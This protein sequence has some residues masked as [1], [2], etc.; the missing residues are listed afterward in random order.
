M[1]DERF[2]AILRLVWQCVVIMSLAYCCAQGMQEKI[3]LD[4][5]W[6]KI[7]C[8]LGNHSYGYIQCKKDN[9]NVEYY[10]KQKCLDEYFDCWECP[11][12]YYKCEHCGKI[13]V[14]KK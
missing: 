5:L 8:L 14:M 11:Y 6:F 13:I 3:M 12:H 9:T 10:D 2:Y 7:Q 1:S 4:K